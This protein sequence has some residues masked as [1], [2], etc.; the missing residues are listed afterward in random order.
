MQAGVSRIACSV[1]KIAPWQVMSFEF[2]QFRCGRKGVLGAHINGSNHDEQ[3]LVPGLDLTLA[4]S[5]FLWTKTPNRSIED[6]RDD[7]CDDRL[8]LRLL[9]GLCSEFPTGG[10]GLVIA[11]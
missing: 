3:P 5:H 11:S 6:V 10:C 1:S 8:V 2:K 4:D 7:T 9:L